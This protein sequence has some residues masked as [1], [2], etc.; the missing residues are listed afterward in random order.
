MIQHL[1]NI[2]LKFTCFLSLLQHACSLQI[3]AGEAGAVETFPS[4]FL[5]GRCV[6]GVGAEVSLKPIS[7]ASGSRPTVPGPGSGEGWWPGPSKAEVSLAG[8]RAHVRHIRGRRPASLCL[9]LCPVGGGVAWVAQEGSQ[10]LLP[11]LSGGQRSC[12]SHRC[13]DPNIFGEEVHRTPRDAKGG[14][15]LVSCVLN[16]FLSAWGL[17]ITVLVHTC[18]SM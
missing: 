10:A 6:C 15:T 3:R 7:R 4:D 11:R 13:W 9:Q 2:S 17:L 12:C 14:R 8:P 5:A 16:G 18:V 1:I